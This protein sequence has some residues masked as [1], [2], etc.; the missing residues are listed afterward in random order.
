MALDEIIITR[1]IIDRY[2]GSWQIWETEAAIVGS[3]PSG[4]VT[5]YF[6]AKEPAKGGIVRA[7]N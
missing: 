1:A 7:G 2:Y 6:L 5:G 3:R 4:L